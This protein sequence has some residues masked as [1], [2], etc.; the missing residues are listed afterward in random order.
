MS[1]IFQDWDANCGNPKGRIILVL[2]RLANALKRGPRLWL[3][4]TVIYG[5]FYRLFVEWILGVELPWKTRVGSGLRLDH[6]QGLVVNDHAIIGKNCHLRHATTIG[7]KEHPDGTYSGS[8]VIGDSVKIG[9]HVVILGAVKVG[10]NAV[11]GAGSVVTKDVPSGA[12][13]VGNPARVLKIRDAAA[14]GPDLQ[15]A[16]NR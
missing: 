2:F 3:P 10:D 5:I 8:P 16:S 4:A 1:S 7:N 13:V 6:G 14:Q 11:I 15:A 12:T 9:A